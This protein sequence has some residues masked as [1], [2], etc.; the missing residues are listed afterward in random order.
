MSDF[1]GKASEEWR[2]ADKLP[3]M[4]DRLK[5][6]DLSDDGCVRLCAEILRGLAAEYVTAKRQHLLQHSPETRRAVQRLRDVFY[7]DWYRALSCGL[8]EPQAVLDELD[9]QARGRRKNDEEVRL[10]CKAGRRR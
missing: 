3:R 10:F 5:P 6:E 7:S 4:A 8:V 2:N 9:R 1:D